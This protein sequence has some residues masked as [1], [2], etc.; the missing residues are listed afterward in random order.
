LNSP[1]YVKHYLGY[2][3]SDKIGSYGWFA[4][5]NVGTGNEY[6]FIDFTKVSEYII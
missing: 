5:D 2:G 4:G 1:E 6:S 3:G